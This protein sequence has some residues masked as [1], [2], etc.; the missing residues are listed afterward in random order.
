[1]KSRQDFPEGTK[2]YY[3]YLRFYYAGLAMASLIA[4]GST[5]EEEIAE[6]SLIL[7]E[8]LL[9]R[10]D[11]TIIV[12]PPKEKI[13]DSGMQELKRA[14]K[15]NKERKEI[16][17]LVDSAKSLFNAKAYKSAL[18][19]YEE[20]LVLSP[21]NKIIQTEIKRCKQWVKAV[22]DLNVLEE[23]EHVQFVT[24]HPNKK[25]DEFTTDFPNLD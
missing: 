10:L 24:N 6:A 9:K 22:E 20:A 13:E 8:A 21:N 15:K 4:S 23:G 3:E 1:M 5:Q 7:S 2:A 12:Y 18:N 17:D 25:Q 14:E 19:K 16:L 11:K